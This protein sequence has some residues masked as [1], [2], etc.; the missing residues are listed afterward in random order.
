MEGGAARRKMEAKGRKGRQGKAG[1]GRRRS[2]SDITTCPYSLDI[3]RISFYFL[4]T[5]NTAQEL[6]EVTKVDKKKTFLTWHWITK[7]I[8][9]K[10][11]KYKNAK[12]REK[13]RS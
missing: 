4:P 8:Y 12:K 5:Y 13:K 11:N 10:K 3:Q 1:E 7:K 2:E 6:T 9:K